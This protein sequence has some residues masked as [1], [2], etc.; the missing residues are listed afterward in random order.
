MTY[1]LP[2][3]LKEEIRER[4][5][6]VA[7][8]SET[9]KLRRAGSNYQGLCPFHKEKSPSFSVS[10][11][12]GIFYCFGCKEGGDAFRFVMKRDNVPFPVAL[13][14]LAQL[15]GVDLSRYENPGPGG[16]QGPKLSRLREAL[17]RAQQIFAG[18]LGSGIPAWTY[19]TEK[20]GLTAATI[21]SYGIG[22]AKD[23][24]TQITD[25]LRGM[26]FSDEELLL[27][28]LSRTSDNRAEPYDVFRDRITFPIHD[29]QGRIVGFGGRAMDPENPA[30][31]LNS[32]ESPLFHKRS[33]LFN[34]NRAKDH[35]LSQGI[36][37][38]EGYMDVI[39]LWQ[40]GVR[41][42]VATLGT[43]LTLNHIRKLARLSSQLHLSFDGD[44]AGLKATVKSLE[45]LHEDEQREMRL[46]VLSLPPG[47]DPDEVVKK[48]GMAA[49]N[50]VLAKADDV[51]GFLYDHTIA[52]FDLNDS[53]G[54]RAAFAELR[55]LFKLIPDVQGKDLFIRRTVDRFEL[56]EELVRENF[57]K[58]R[59]RSAASFR[60]EES[61]GPARE[62]LSS[63]TKK[64]RYL[65]AHFLG[66]VALYLRL[67]S[68]LKQDDFRDPVCRETIDLIEKLGITSG[69]VL[70]MILSH[71]EG[72]VHRFVAEV[73]MDT[74]LPAEERENDARQT[75]DA[76][77]QVSLEDRLSD[78]KKQI[79]SG[80]MT[81]LE[82]FQEALKKRVFAK[83][84]RE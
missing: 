19:L 58:G 7:V 76:L 52:A 43:A 28:G 54:K 71:S 25:H 31:Y 82:H 57:I 45:L 4:I 50:A 26:G 70:D 35:D 6:L 72:E 33:L 18:S 74:H 10:P 49:W 59:S 5:D 13:E 22:F 30:K 21:Q 16:A 56:S 32:P 51:A 61:S 73:T 34:L 69:P 29:D 62:K 27:S 36:V 77:R 67:K 12:K 1:R 83:D 80:E 64:E 37:L 11:D 20:R 15:A 81:S 38:V 75:L 48:D 41:N 79:R 2:P 9:V 24:W 47:L 42:V 8:V 84:A 3:E 66:D 53:S 65:V 17:E 44:T 40:A 46:K 55:S 63:A 78:M 39:G 14:K 23:S 60:E 68:E